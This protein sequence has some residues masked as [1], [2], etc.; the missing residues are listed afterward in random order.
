MKARLAVVVCIILMAVMLWA[1][2]T[3][4]A[5][6]NVGIKVV[7]DKETYVT[8][9]TA[10]VTLTLTGLKDEKSAGVKLGAFETHLQFNETVDEN[11]L[12]YVNGG[13]E[14]SLEE[15][16]NSTNSAKEFRV[17][18]LFKNII[19]IVFDSQTG[20]DLESVDENGNLVIG[21]VSF[22]VKAEKGSTVKTTFASDSYPN[23]VTKPFGTTDK[24]QALN[25]TISGEATAK[26][27]D[28]VIESPTAVFNNNAVSG[29]VSVRLPQSESG[30]LLAV[31]RDK[32]SGLV[33][34]SN[35]KNISSTGIY[36][37]SFEG[38]TNSSNLKIDYYLW[39]SFFSMKAIAESVSAEVTT[40]N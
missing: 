8:G 10:K 20:I 29:T 13:F 37:V 11:K 3:Y 16:L 30:V 2:Y 22:K 19:V 32:T 15:K 12:E 27:V 35:I 17:T 23:V 25:C 33:K 4:A 6:N 36:D 38:I 14:S 26:I 28:G 39:K 40:G 31:L 34:K 9:D 5:D 18:E 7:F 1:P 21:T 24:G